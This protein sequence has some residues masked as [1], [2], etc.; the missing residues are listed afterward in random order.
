[1]GFAGLRGFFG[2]APADARA[3]EG[4]GFFLVFAL[5]MVLSLTPSGADAPDLSQRAA[6]VAPAR[7]RP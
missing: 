4:A 2:L 7:A 3:R 5:G 6:R 1:M